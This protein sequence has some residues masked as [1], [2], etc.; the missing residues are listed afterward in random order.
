MGLEELKA[1][2]RAE[3]IDQELWTRFDP[4]FPSLQAERLIQVLVRELSQQLL[5]KHLAIQLVMPFQR[6]GRVISIDLFRQNGLIVK[7]E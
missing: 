7:A 2:K 6:S 5:V 1:Y 3:Y 4:D